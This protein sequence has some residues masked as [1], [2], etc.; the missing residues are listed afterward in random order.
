MDD[1]PHSRSSAQPVWDPKDRSN[2]CS[3]LILSLF[4]TLHTGTFS[5]YPPLDDCLAV[6]IRHC[7][8]LVAVH[9]VNSHSF[10]RACVIAN[11]AVQ[12]LHGIIN[13]QLTADTS[14]GQSNDTATVDSR[15][16]LSQCNLS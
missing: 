8:N 7:A 6:L 13:L 16:N 10:I 3:G 11:I 12:C 1:P 5:E 4:T 9:T 14:I 15:E 2:L